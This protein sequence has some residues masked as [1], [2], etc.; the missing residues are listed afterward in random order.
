MYLEMH[1]IYCFFER[2][3][4]FK[5]GGGGWP[6]IPTLLSIQVYLGCFPV[7]LAHHPNLRTPDYAWTVLHTGIFI[8]TYL[9]ASAWLEQKA[10]RA[11]SV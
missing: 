9:N 10:M 11:G 1:V 8:Q 4:L 7:G 6:I 2:V 5:L 3:A